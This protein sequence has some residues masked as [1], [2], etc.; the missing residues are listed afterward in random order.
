MLFTVT[1]RSKTGAKA[2]VEIEAASRAACMAEC[3]RKGIAPVGIREGGDSSRPRAAGTAAPRDGRTEARPSPKRGLYLA[4]AVLCAAVLGGGLWW[5]LARDESR[6][7]RP[8]QSVAEQKPTAA[9]RS[10]RAADSKPSAASAN[11]QDAGK[12]PK[13]KPQSEARVATDAPELPA[14]P[15]SATNTPSIPPLPPSTFSNASDQVLAMIASADASG[16]LPPLPISRDIEAEFLASLKQEIVI[17]DTDDEKTRAIKQAVKESREELK[18]LVDSGMTVAQVLAEHQHLAS[19]NA[20]VRND[21]ML[22]LRQLIES[23]DIE[24]AK[25]Y[26]RK[27]NIALQQMG[28]AE[29][30][31]PVTDEERAERAVARRERMLKKRAAQAAEAEKLKKENHK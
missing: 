2:E 17:L 31:I 3:K 24:G 15:D 29:M 12:R 11:A 28:I 9:P 13:T 16:S 22:E 19:E 14:L 21:A 27:I 30:T 4:V 26:K 18:R 23:G 1:Y 10:A 8:K 7:S 25:E 20:R 5:W 6:A